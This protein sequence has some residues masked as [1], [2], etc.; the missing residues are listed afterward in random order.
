MP[1]TKL[2]SETLSKRQIP[3][4]LINR[5]AVEVLR[6]ADAIALF[7]VMA[8]KPEGWVFRKEAL[9]RRLGMGEHRYRSAMS[10][11]EKAG[12]VSYEVKRDDNGQLAGRVIWF[13][14]VTEASVIHASVEPTLGQSTLIENREDYAK[15]VLLEN[16]DKTLDQFPDFDEF[17]KL[18]PRRIAK[19]KAFLKWRRL[20]TDQRRAALDHLN[21]QP[22]ADVDLQFVPHPTTYLNQERWIDESDPRPEDLPLLGI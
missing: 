7:V 10:E 1:V 3:Y 6:T 19:N 22:F 20:K 8:A 21:R 13:S 17:W 16:R 4:D 12:F 2:D 18:Y 14:Q 15:T 9:K 5:E 11:L